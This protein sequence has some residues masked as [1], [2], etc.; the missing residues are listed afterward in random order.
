L[1]KGNPQVKYNTFALIVIMISLGGASQYIKDLLKFG[2]PSPYLDTTGY[3]Q[4]AVYA[5]GVIGQYER[6]ADVVSPLY[7]SRDDWLMSTILGEAGPTVRNI[8]TLGS[9]IGLGMQGE[10]ERAISKG[11][12]TA[13]LIAPVTSV[14]KGIAQGLTG[15]NPF[16]NTTVGNIA[17]EVADSAENLARKLFN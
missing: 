17:G 8:Q 10:G 14:R 12:G 11:L 9:A 1:R 5:S 4:R 15:T 16:E 13:P 3:A 7:P 6:L 2:K